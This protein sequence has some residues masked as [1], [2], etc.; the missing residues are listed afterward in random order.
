MKKVHALLLLA[1]PLVA[2]S[3]AVDA[4]NAPTPARTLTIPHYAHSAPLDSIEAEVL[5][6]T[7]KVRAS[8]ATCGDVAM[9]PV[10][11]LS[12]N[13]QLRDA[14]IWH[15]ADMAARSYFDHNAPEGDDA[16]VRITAARYT[17]RTWGENIAR[18]FMD[19]EAVVRAWVASPGHCHN[20][21]TASFRELGVGV[22]E[23]DLGRVWTQNFASR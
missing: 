13:D 12:M 18:N 8:G 15:S 16:G 9:P 19:P 6:L 1:A 7:N 3:G 23:S 14:A 22:V 20:L 17:Y 5:R 2:C 21:M 10:P 11:L 4:G